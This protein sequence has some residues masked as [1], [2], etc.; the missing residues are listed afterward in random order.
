[1]IEKLDG[2]VSSPHPFIQNNAVII[3]CHGPYYVSREGFASWALS[4][5]W[6]A[7]KLQ[8]LWF[9]PTSSFY[10]CKNWDLDT[11]RREIRRGSIRQG[12]WADA[13]MALGFLICEMGVSVKAFWR[14]PESVREDKAQLALCRG[15]RGPGV[16]VRIIII[17][18]RS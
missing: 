9:S 6:F 3:F 15:P 13:Y 1:M 10:R 11:A 8:K 18:I 17:I 5:A 7:F 12:P 4:I 16:L 2:W 14:G